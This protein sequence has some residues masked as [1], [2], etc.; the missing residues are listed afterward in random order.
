MKYT[1]V[2]FTSSTIEEWQ[3]DL[4]IA[5]L[6]NLGFDTFEDQGQGFVGLCA[7]I[8]LGHPGFGNSFGYGSG[9]L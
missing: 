8:Q 1:A 7:I 6:A 9:W 5:E 4:L 3:K 2:T